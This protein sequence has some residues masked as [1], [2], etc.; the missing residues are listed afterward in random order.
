MCL[1]V[2]G[3]VVEVGGE[4]ATVEVAG[5]RSQVSL[6]LLTADETPA[7][8]DYLV[9]HLGMALGR[10]DQPEAMELMAMLQEVAGVEAPEEVGVE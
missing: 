8:G 10:I 5:K 7:I 1:A 6:R 2:P 9:F 4:V 3:R